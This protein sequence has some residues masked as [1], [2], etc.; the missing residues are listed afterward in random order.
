MRRAVLLQSAAF[1]VLALC[2]ARDP[3]AHADAPG[4]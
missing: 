2:I 4:L 1:A 3:A